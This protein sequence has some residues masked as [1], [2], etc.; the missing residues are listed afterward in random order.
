MVL[1]EVVEAKRDGRQA[2]P[3]HNLFKSA[4]PQI[5]RLEHS[6]IRFLPCTEGVVILPDTSPP[7]K[8]GSGKSHNLGEDYGPSRLTFRLSSY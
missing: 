8:Y 3:L 7:D 1:F 2:I 4:R 5:L 6:S